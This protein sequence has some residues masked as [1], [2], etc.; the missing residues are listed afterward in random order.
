MGQME[1]IEEIK[2]LTLVERISLVEE[3]MKLIGEDIGSRR[4]MLPNN[5]EIER[6]MERA[7]ELLKEDY[8]S[9]GALTEFTA[10]DGEDF[11]EER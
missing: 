2:K 9:G 4:K 8:R 11:D 3:T 10:L 1:I 6:Q 7:A 5:D